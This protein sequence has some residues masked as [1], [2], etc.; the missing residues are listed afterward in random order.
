MLSREECELL[1]RVDP[2]TPMG[3]LMRRYW[4]PVV[5][6]HQIPKPD[7]PPVRAKLLGENLVAFRDTSGK[8]GLVAEACPHRLASLFYGRNEE[9]GL[10]CVYHGIKFDRD[11]N[12]M[13]VPCIAPGTTTETQMKAIKRQMRITAYP[14]EER[15][16][17]VWAYMGPA[18]LKPEFPELEWANVPASHR[19][20]T[21]HVQ[22]C[23]WLQGIDGGFDAAHLSFLHSG[24]VDARKGNTDQHR[25]IVPSRYHVFPIDG[26]FACTGGRD[27]GDG[28]F[29]WHV[30]IMLM[31][32]HKIVPSVPKAAHIWMPMDDE[33]TMLYSINFDPHKALT[34]EDLERETAWRGIHTENIPGTDR[35]VLN[36]D[37]DYLIDRELQASGKSF[38]GLKGLGV[39]DCGMQESMGPIVDRTSEHLLPCDAALTQIRALLLRAVRD[40]AAG[41]TP[42]G[43][44]G[45]S[46]RVRSA[47]FE[48]QLTNAFDETVRDAI[49]IDRPVAAE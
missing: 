21:R 14:C 16:D 5:F 25:R 3:E 18:E 37:N 32:F 43:M 36:K 9:G 30:E 34:E 44:K 29:S 45:A 2:G 10:R 33:T 49:S 46:Y 47:R 23:N 27:I 39:Q 13:D 8:P 48:S 28:S 19:F 17:L 35:P 24:A 11:G 41:K 15:G 20:A 26:G 1:T 42:P 31:P 38:T 4:V 40:H 7:C 12:C 6:S 22:E